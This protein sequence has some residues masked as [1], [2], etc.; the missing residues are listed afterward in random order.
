MRPTILF[1]FVLGAASPAAA[2]H[3]GSTFD[4]APGA[5]GGGGLFYT[6]APRERGW[7]CAACH[8]DAP[9]ALRV[10]LTDDGDLFASRT[11]EPGR[12]YAIR[13][14]IDEER[15]G[16]GAGRS[17]FNGMAVTMS[18]ESPGSLGGY[19]ASQFYARGANILAT[20]ATRAGETEWAFTWTAPEAGAGEVRMFL[21]VVDGNGADSAPDETL[22]DPFGDDVATGAFVFTERGATGRTPEGKGGEISR[23]A[24]S[25]RR[26]QKRYTSSQAKKRG[27]SAR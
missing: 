3:V 13:V 15:L 18:G 22:T 20:S 8:T 12:A 7:T 4:A 9:G 21:G 10:R 17:N 24:S 1:L 19:D 25:P 27:S 2:W 5:G 26:A 23:S 11:Y 16:L 14:A 6:G